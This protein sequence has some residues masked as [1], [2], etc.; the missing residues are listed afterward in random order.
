MAM[1]TKTARWQDALERKVRAFY[2]SLNQHKVAACF[3]MIDPQVRDVPGSVTLYQYGQALHEFVDR[4][5]P[6]K[7]RAIHLTLHLDEPNQLYQ[8]RDFAIGKTTW[9]DAAGNRY[10]FLERWVRQDRSW[11]TRSTGFV[12]PVPASSVSSANEVASQHQGSES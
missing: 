1:T 3:Q 12:T 9:L 6:L 8:G 10:V 4:F 7:V 5:G 11:Y 2:K